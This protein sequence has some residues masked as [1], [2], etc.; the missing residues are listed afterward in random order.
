MTD[1]MIRDYT[2]KISQGSKSDIIVILYDLAIGYMEEAQTAFERGDH[3]NARKECTNA[4]RVFG[5]LIG[6]LDFSYEISVR[7]F[8]IYEFLSK[9]VSMAVIKDDSG[10]LSA[11]VRLM[12]SLKESFEKLAKEDTSGPMMENAQTVYT[13]LTYGR[14]TLNDSMDISANNRGFK[15]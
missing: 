15:V 7:L 9:E 6:A 4:Q 10:R 13:G 1:E 2:R 11:P 3:E 5:D 12:K 14:G 8:R